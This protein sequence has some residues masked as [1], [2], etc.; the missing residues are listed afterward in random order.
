MKTIFKYRQFDCKYFLVNQEGSGITLVL[1][2]ASMIAVF[3]V[4]IMKTAKDQAD[5][6]R[7]IEVRIAADKV[8]E[9]I[10][11]VLQY[12]TT[13]KMNLTNSNQGPGLTDRNSVTSMPTAGVSAT[14][15]INDQSTVLFSVNNT[16]PYHNYSYIKEIKY[17]VED[18]VNTPD[19]VTMHIIFRKSK[20]IAGLSN[21]VMLQRGRTISRKILIKMDYCTQRDLSGSNFAQECMGA[22]LNDLKDCYAFFGDPSEVNSYDDNPFKNVCNNIG[23]RYNSAN[24][25]CDL[26]DY[27][28]IMIRE[29][30]TEMRNIIPGTRSLCNQMGADW[31]PQTRRCGPINPNGSCPVGASIIGWD[32]DGRFIC[33]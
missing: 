9:D 32:D 28:S 11:S 23:G 22:Q 4:N 3:G 26:V 5:T 27:Q 20:E 2:L 12:Y 25:R 18:P 8:T 13:C 10:R 1:V 6:Q 31:N 19:V 24:G 29:G 16:D 15:I 14:G 30:T 21:L 7:N 17:K 33:R